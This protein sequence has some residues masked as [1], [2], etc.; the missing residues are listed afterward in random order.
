MLSLPVLVG[1][2]LYYLVRGRV[3]LDW[4][5]VF[6]PLG[7]L[8]QFVLLVGLGLLL[9]PV[10]VLATDMQRVVRIVLRF[11]FYLSPVLYGTHAVPR[12]PAGGPRR[13]TRSTASCRSTAA[14]CSPAGC[15]GSTSGSASVITRRARSSSGFWT[16]SRLERTVL[17]EI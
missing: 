15:R 11:M 8:L 5:L 1:F 10:T 6:F 17:K 3:D 13:S 12:A 7:M 2:V 4:E 14:G 16:F 9:A